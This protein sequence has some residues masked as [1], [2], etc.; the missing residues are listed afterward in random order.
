M[1]RKLVEQSW[2]EEKQNKEEEEEEGRGKHRR[3]LS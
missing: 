2:K 1:A 3:S